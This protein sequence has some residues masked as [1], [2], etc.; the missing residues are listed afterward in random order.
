[1]SKLF[2]LL[3]QCTWMPGQSC[4]V[5]RNTHRNSSNLILF[6]IVSKKKKKLLEKWFFESFGNEVNKILRKRRV[7]L[8]LDI[9]IYIYILSERVLFSCHTKKVTWKSSNE[10]PYAHIAIN[11][12][13]P[14]SSQRNRVCHICFLETITNWTIYRN[15]KLVPTSKKKV[16]SVL[17][18][19]RNEME[20]V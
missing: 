15:R 6:R 18:N 10:F 17:R 16:I 8:L 7:H 11:H 4:K 3:L 19:A 13:L 20:S 14:H 2:Y 9:Y 12:F 5:K 1:M